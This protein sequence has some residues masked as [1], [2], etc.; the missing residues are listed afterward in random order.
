MVHCNASW[1]CP[2]C[3]RV[4]PSGAPRALHWKNIWKNANDPTRCDYIRVAAPVTLPV[5]AATA[6]AVAVRALD[7]TTASTG[8]VTTPSAYGLSALARRSATSTEAGR[9]CRASYTIVTTPVSTPDTNCR[10]VC[11]LQRAWDLYKSEVLSL[12]CPTFWQFYL[13][14]HHLS[15]SAQDAA[16][17]AAKDTFL[18]RRSV[19]YK[20]FAAS[21]RVL[22]QKINSISQPFWPMVSHT[23]EINLTHFDLPSGTKK[24]TFKFLDPAWGWV[25]AARRLHP[26]D[27]HWKP[28]S[29]RDRNPVYGGG[30][31]FGQAFM[32]ACNSCPAGSYPMPFKLHWDGTGAFGMSCAPLCI[33]VANYNGS[34][35][36]AHCCLGYIPA[37]PD[38]N[39]ITNSTE[40][41]HF[42]RQKCALAV[43]KV[44]ELSART[45]LTCR[46]KN[47]HG[48]EVTRLLFPRLMSMNFDQPE[49][50]LTFGLQNK[51]CCSK[52]KWRQGRSAFRKNS[53]QSGTAV[54]RL[55]I[56]SHDPTATRTHRDKA[57]SKL[58]LWGFNYKRVSC[59]FEVRDVLVRIPGKDEVYPC[60]DFRDFM[61]G[62]KIFLH[63][64]IV[65]DTLAFIGITPRTKRLMLTRLEALY[66]RQT[67]RDRYGQSYRKK[68]QIFSGQNMSAKD[69]VALL[70]TLPHVIGHMSDIFEPAIREPLLTALA[71]AQLLIIACSGMRS[72]TVRELHTIFHR[73]YIRLFGALQTLHTTDYEKRL[74]R[75]RRNPDKV[76]YPQPPPMP[77]RYECLCTCDILHVYLRNFTCVL[78]IFLMCTCDIL[79]VYLRYFVGVLAIFCACTCD[80]M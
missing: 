51:N 63:R 17:K 37:T 50:Q 57:R 80:I 64:V 56:Q 16:L 52:C 48:V 26:L 76:P 9:R 11:V 72:Y 22:T 8:S 61:H 29:Q 2:L 69:K 54:R 15:R 21:K 39:M 78:A 25:V 60:V 44:L 40:V 49:A 34:S 46:L 4:I 79:S 42:I 30:V 31:Q 1:E 24:V 43:L 47:Q 77:Q 23:C 12:F 70:F 19:T 18:Q 66:A 53:S 73:G 10:D 13:P 14:L 20:A 35:P 5:T 65:L 6:A 75:H 67:F 41:K 58:K 32:Q 55:Y 62:L 68:L 74:A 38:A 36:D 59:L 45:G 7:M 27:L 3:L 28:V 71:T 33:G